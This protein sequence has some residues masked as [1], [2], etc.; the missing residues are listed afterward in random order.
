[1]SAGSLVLGNVATRPARALIDADKAVRMAIAA[2]LAPQVFRIAAGPDGYV[3]EFSLREI[4]TSWP[5]PQQDLPYPCASI[6]GPG[7]FGQSDFTPEGLEETQN[8]YGE[9]TSVWKLDEIESTYQIDFFLTNEPEREA[10]AAA[11]PGLF[12]ANDGLGRVWIETPESYLSW[13]MAAMFLG[14]TRGQDP[15]QV[16]SGEYRLSAQVQCSIDVIE[17]RCTSLLVPTSIVQV[18]QQ[19]QTIQDFEG[20]DS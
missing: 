9:G 20:A 3:R 19:P 16:Y 13:P 1:M 17:L 2:Y 8:V 12:M 6:S 7:L 5:L 18:V 10:I 14:L 4:A 15:N 11:L